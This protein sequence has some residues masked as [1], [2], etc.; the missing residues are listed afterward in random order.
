MEKAIK[1]DL[2]T[3]VP[4]ESAKCPSDVPVEKD[5]KFNCTVALA[6]GATGKVTV[7]QKGLNKYTYELKPGSVQIP[8]SV[9]EASVQKDL[10]AQGIANATVN[11]PDN[12]IVKVGTTVTCDVTGAS[13]VAS[14]T[15]TFTFSDAEGTVDPDS[16][17]A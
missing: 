8:G 11:C 2:G 1:D 4:V 10:A 14:G 5:D 13:G 15:V 12:I 17:K 6:N 3:S 9:A 16:V 7:T